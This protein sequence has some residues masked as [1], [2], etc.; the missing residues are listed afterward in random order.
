MKIRLA[1]RKT[2][3]FMFN[4]DCI[5]FIKNLKIN[6]MKSLQTQK[7]NMLKFRRIKQQTLNKNKKIKTILKIFLKINQKLLVIK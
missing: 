4:C 2:Y 1:N 7:N 3:T 5:F 6:L